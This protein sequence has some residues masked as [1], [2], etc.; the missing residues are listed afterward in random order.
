MS[1]EAKALLRIIAILVV[2]YSVTVITC[3]AQNNLAV[4]TIA[5][6]S[7][8]FTDSTVQ[9]QYITDLVNQVT[10]AH[11][12]NQIGGMYYN[13]QSNKWKVYNGGSWVDL[14]PAAGGSVTA[15][16]GLT[17]TGSNITLG[18]TLTGNTTINGG[19]FGFVLQ[20]ASGDNF[21]TGSFGALF[22]QN[23]ISG[24]SGSIAGE[25][26]PNFLMNRVYTNQAAAN[27]HGFI[28]QNSFQR[29]T[30]AYASFDVQTN[31]TGGISMDHLS[32]FQ[33]RG[34][35]TMTGT[36]T[37]MY[38]HRF[39]PA[40]LTNGTLTNRYD[41]I[42]VAG[43]SGTTITNKYAFFASK[44]GGPSSGKRTGN[45]S[46]YSDDGGDPSFFGAETR[47]ERTTSTTNAAVGVNYISARSTG[48]IASGFMPSQTWLQTTSAGTETVLG[49]TGMRRTTAANTA[50][51]VI[52]N[53]RA[54]DY[55]DKYT[56]TSGGNIILGNSTFS[57]THQITTSS[58]A[59]QADLLID[60]DGGA[61]GNAGT[62][63]IEGRVDSRDGY[64]IAASDGYGTSDYWF[65]RTTQIGDW[66]M[67]ANS[68][69]TITLPPGTTYDK[70]LSVSVTIFPDTGAASY[71][72]TSMNSIVTGVSNGAVNG[73]SA[74]GIDLVRMTSGLFDDANFDATGFNRGIVTITYKKT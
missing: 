56:F 29:A 72:L 24:V 1:K 74:S 51:W 21:Q 20:N 9:K 36:L 3:T 60:L 55:S 38:G 49:V 54:G 31:M 63:T 65:I 28:D 69:V 17:K 25:S 35:M 19:A 6:Y 41:F 10:P 57:T 4:K 30:Q 67:D 53:G 48:T 70:I 33:F 46:F 27:E 34:K 68:S 40:N 15:S 43:S 11:N 7:S 16:N 8:N 22:S 2:I 26:G 64:R 52:Q 44:N 37:N 61:V 45:W 18:G 47:T 23:V 14:I 5:S 58:N 73:Y 39:D 32:G 12:A 13:W 62:L 42:S 66:N 50:D 71:N 59:T